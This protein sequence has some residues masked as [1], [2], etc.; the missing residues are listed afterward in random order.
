M[1]LLLLL[2]GRRVLFL[3]LEHGRPQA[4]ILGVQCGQLL[5]LP[6]HLLGLRAQLLVLLL[7][8][9]EQQ[10]DQLVILHR[11]DGPAAFRVT[12]SG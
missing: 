6:R 3:L 12:N 4:R 8:F 2:Y 11:L 1:L 5:R 10:R 9:L 7:H